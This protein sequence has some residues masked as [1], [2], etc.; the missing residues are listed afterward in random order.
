[1]FF[2]FTL[3][4]SPIGTQEPTFV[5]VK[6]PAERLLEAARAAFV[7]LDLRIAAQ[8]PDQPITLNK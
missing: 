4:R 5:Y 7:G 2:P 1:V 8:H 6:T 3:N